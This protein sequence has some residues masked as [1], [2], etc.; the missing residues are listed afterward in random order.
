[1]TKMIPLTQGKFAMVDDA[2]FEWL[3][4]WKWCLAK[5]RFVCY[6]VRHDCSVHPYKNL[7]MHRVI[8]AASGEQWIDHRNGDGLDNRRSN[9]R[10]CSRG[11]NRANAT[12]R[13]TGGSQYKGVSRSRH[14]DRWRASICIRGEIIRLGTFDS[15][16]D[17]ARAYD[18]AALRGFADFAKPNVIPSE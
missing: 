1:M 11:Q 17:A 10:F 6:A 9:L 5:T 15:E 14:G 13:M 16:E 18:A 3:N 4:Q 7:Y 2:D 12:K 8:M